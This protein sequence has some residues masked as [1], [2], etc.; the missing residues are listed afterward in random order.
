MRNQI[1]FQFS[2][3]L[4]GQNHVLYGQND[5]LFPLNYGRENLT[6]KNPFKFLSIEQVKNMFLTIQ[7]KPGCEKS[8]SKGLPGRSHGGSRGDLRRLERGQGVIRGG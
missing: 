4:N 8:R 3:D 5:G 1:S 7:H 2:I 6:E